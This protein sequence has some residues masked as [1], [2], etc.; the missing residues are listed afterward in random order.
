M[1]SLRP[2]NRTVEHDLAAVFWPADE[3]HLSTGGAVDLDEEPDPEPIENGRLPLARVIF[4]T[5]ASAIDPFPRADDA[6]MD[7]TPDEGDSKP[8][9]PFAALAKLKK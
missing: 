9:S 5:F 7:W 1:V 2:L 6:V 3:M 4:E 8:A